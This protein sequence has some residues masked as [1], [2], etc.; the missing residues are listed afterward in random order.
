MNE[1]GKTIKAENLQRTQA[2]G[3]VDLPAQAASETPMMRQYW[4]AKQRCPRHLLFFRLG[5]FYEMFFEDAKI[6]SR[7]LGLTLTSRSKGADAV[8][9]AGI[10]VHTA[11]QYLAKLLRQGFSVAVCDQTEDPS[12]T[13]KLIRREITRI[14]TPGTVLEDNL[15]EATRPNRIAAIFPE[16]AVKNSFSA[17]ARKILSPKR[18]PNVEKPASADGETFGLAFTDLT[19]GEIFVLE[20]TGLSAL[21]S[22]L[23]RLSPSE[24]LLPEPPPTPPGAKVEAFPPKSENDTAARFFLRPESFEPRES[25]A[26]LQRRFGEEKSGWPGLRRSK[27]MG[28]AAAGALLGYLEETHVGGQLRL[29]PPVEFDPAERLLL[30]AAALHSL[31]IFET[32][33]RHAY[34]GS[35]LWS[36][37]RTQTGA[38]A[39]CLR[40]WLIRPL[41]DLNAIRRRQ[42][43]V[44]ALAEDSTMRSNVRTL[45]RGTADL[46]RIAARLAAGRA[47]PRDLLA[48]QETLARLPHFSNLFERL[49]PDGLLA[50]AAVGLHGLSEIGERIAKV[51]RDDCSHAADKGGLI[52]AGVSVELDRLLAIASGGKEWIAALQA[53]EC[54]RT[55]ISSLKIGY[56]RVF[57]YYIEISRAHKQALPADYERRQTLAGAERYVTPAL[58]ER[59]TEV[60]GA[61]DKSRE[62]EK[63]LFEELREQTAAAAARL[64]AAGRLLSELDALA[65]FADVAARRGHVRPVLT[66]T[67]RLSFSQLRHPVLEETL[68]RGSLV[69]NDLTLDVSQTGEPP[70]ILLITGPNMA[71]KSTYIRAAALAVILAQAG[72]FVPAEKAEIGLVDRVLTRIGAADDVA[73][74]RSTFMVEMGEVADILS[75]ASDRSL[76]ILDEVG[77]GTSTYD[78]VSLAWALVEHLH[79]GPA[80]PRTLFATHYHELC[81]L[82]EELPRVAN[83]SAAVK[84]WQGE[85]TFLHRITSGPS[86]KSFGIHVARL[87]GL[88]A[89]LLD[90]AKRIL[91]ELEA[92]AEERLE[93]LTAGGSGALMP[94]KIRNS[95]KKIKPT[96]SDGQLFLFEP[97]EL[98]LEPEVKDILDEIRATDPHSLSPLEAINRLDHLVRKAKGEK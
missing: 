75:A 10:P 14:V 21:V 85:I 53:E 7:V 16:R 24:I 64:S 57:G 98:A 62:L 81:A 39:R 54:K 59:E 25:F 60:L 2:D 13:K 32:L 96:A 44:A 33:R 89:P 41:C 49:P 1:K 34:E 28:T 22:E 63:R 15:L 52:R 70:Q 58:K 68:P 72:A 87:A 47:T 5:D 46:E 6:A 61:E 74:G 48:L 8:P 77:R 86:E 71:G 78:G 45:L 11:E 56:N 43:A 55:G 79:D 12:K 38:G 90:R 9:M 95:R 19:G 27:P 66:N 31:E 73:G 50:Q 97:D 29:L 76:L 18:K 36:V 80:K 88:P 51:L 35:L 93:C 94:Q 4:E 40:E 82:A 92:E 69:P 67:R 26:R 91:T 20:L 65:S 17:D 23:E 37:D 84:E 42:D 30:N 83:A 3:F